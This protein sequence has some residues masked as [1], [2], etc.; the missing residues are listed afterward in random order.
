MSYG[1][2]V[3]VM[4]IIVKL[5]MQVTFTRWS[6][7]PWT[8]DDKMEFIIPVSACQIYNKGN[9]RRHTQAFVYKKVSY[10]TLLDTISILIQT[11]KTL[12]KRKKPNN[13]Q[14][15]QCSFFILYHATRFSICA[16]LQSKWTAFTGCTICRLLST[17]SL[18]FNIAETHDTLYPWSFYVKNICK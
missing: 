11:L 9:K 5:H 7:K 13:I 3:I 15:T 2:I 10:Q 8:S 6:S 1:S 4:I 12:K 16:S 17:K 14:H 18:V